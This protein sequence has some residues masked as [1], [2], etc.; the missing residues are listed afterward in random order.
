[1]NDI[2]TLRGATVVVVGDVMLDEYVWGVVKRISPEAP[3]PV[4]EVQSRSHAAGGAANVAAGIIALD[5]QAFL[6]GVVGEDEA[7]RGLRDALAAAGVDASDLVVDGSRPTT[8]KTRVIAHSQQVV[9]TDYEE[10]APLSATIEAAVLERVRERVGQADAVVLSDYRKGVVSEV[11][12][13]GVIDAAAAAGKPVVV[14]PKGLNY[15][16]Y[17]GATVITP[18]ADD[19]AKTANVHIESEDDLLEAA[20]RLSEACDGAAL[21]VTRGAAGMSL[22]RGDS[23]FD[24]P[25]QARDVYDVTG[26]GDTVVALLAIALGRAWPLEEAVTLANAAAGVVVGKIGT[27]TVTL[28]ELADGLS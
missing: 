8:S 9:R 13:R 3:V 21:L 10:I 23:R 11:V 27:S 7:A 2:S 5:G 19:A 12:A 6:G 18:N 14:D 26:A 4:V 28:E 20:R 17:R 24:V 1:M 25:T 15:A 22:F 16:R